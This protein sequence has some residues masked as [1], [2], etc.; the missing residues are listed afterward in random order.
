MHVEVSPSFPAALDVNKI[1]SS[2]IY[3]I[4]LSICFVNAAKIYES[5]SNPVVQLMA[6]KYSF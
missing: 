5:D 3:A 1:N 6:I 2:L 4:L